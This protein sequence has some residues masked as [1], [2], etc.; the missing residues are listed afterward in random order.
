MLYQ[1]RCLSH[2]SAIWNSEDLTNWKGE[3]GRRTNHGRD[4][5]V[6][7]TGNS[8][9]GERGKQNDQFAATHRRNRIYRGAWDALHARLSWPPHKKTCHRISLKLRTERCLRYWP[10]PY[11]VP[12]CYTTTNRYRQLNG[13]CFTYLYALQTSCVDLISTTKIRA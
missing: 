2:L 13:T 4:W 10:V 5:E 3:R 8:K 11:L 12:D 6:G 1:L 9:I 7:V